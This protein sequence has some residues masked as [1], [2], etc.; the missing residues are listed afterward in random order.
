MT[1][2]LAQLADEATDFRGVVL[3][4]PTTNLF[5][6]KIDYGRGEDSKNLGILIGE[7]PRR[8]NQ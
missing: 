6:A 5:Q 8:S 1:L 7:L 3:E 2:M 4:K